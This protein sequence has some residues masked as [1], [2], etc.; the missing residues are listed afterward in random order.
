MV[1]KAEFVCPK[2]N[3]PL[4]SWREY[5]HQEEQDIDKKTGLL[6][7]QVIKRKPKWTEP[8][9]IECR[10]CGAAW[11]GSKCDFN[12][13]HIAKIFELINKQGE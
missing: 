2:C 10:N 13:S 8:N 5:V 11:S 3:G 6:K 9:G 12:D 7:K 4:F 1:M